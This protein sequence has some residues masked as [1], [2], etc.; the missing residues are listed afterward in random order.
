MQQVLAC[1]SR[2]S[3]NTQVYVFGSAI[4]PGGHQPN[5]IDILVLYDCSELPSA[6]RFCSQLRALATFPPLDV[7][8]LS[9]DEESETD[10]ICGVRAEK[11]W[12][13]LQRTGN[14]HP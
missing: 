1:C 11:I 5:D 13:E 9:T 2:L 3:S 7:L 6:H 12:P 4:H 8:A 10:F 14:Q